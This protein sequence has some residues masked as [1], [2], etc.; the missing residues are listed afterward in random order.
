M[1]PNILK[2]IIEDFQKLPGIGEKTAERLALHLVTKI[3]NDEI[4]QFSNHL[5]N[6]KE[7]IKYCNK[8]HMITDHDV[9]EICSNPNRD[10]HIIMVVADAKDVFVM[11]KMKTY[12]GLYHVLGGLVD[13][14][15]GITD[16]DLNIDTLEERLKNAKEM[17]I[18]TSGT[19]E[20]EMTAKYLKS[21][22]DDNR[23]SV[24]RLAYGL[25]VGADLKYADELTLSKAVE[26][27]LKY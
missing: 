7:E 26:N 11:E 4:I 6:L 3:D 24:T 19:V 23:L 21:L 22:F 20:G 5:A 25:P 2:K 8:C 16:K 13:F 15:R 12:H 17:I 14:S 1:Y 18:A 10:H 27:R 9:C